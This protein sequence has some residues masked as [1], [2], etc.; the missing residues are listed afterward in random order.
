[1]QEKNSSSETPS[2]NSP[3]R[4]SEI[5]VTTQAKRLKY[6][7]PYLHPIPYEM[8]PKLLALRLYVP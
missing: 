1:M 3:Y 7:G 8:H 2:T 6:L 5:P 4:F